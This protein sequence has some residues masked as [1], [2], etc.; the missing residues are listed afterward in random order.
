MYRIVKGLSQPDE[1]RIPPFNLTITDR[2]DA[3]VA[4]AVR[5]PITVVTRGSGSTHQVLH[6]DLPKGLEAHGAAV[7]PDG[8]LLLL[9][10]RKRDSDAGKHKALTGTDLYLYGFGD[11]ALSRVTQTPEWE[12]AMSFSTDGTAIYFIR[13]WKAT[14]VKWHFRWNI[15]R[16]D[17]AGQREEL[18]FSLPVQGI[19]PTSNL[20]VSP[21]NNKIMFSAIDRNG[22]GGLFLVELGAA[23]TLRKVVGGGSGRDYYPIYRAPSFSRSGKEVVFI[24]GEKRVDKPVW[25]GV[26]TEELWVMRTD[27]SAP[28]RVTSN[29]FRKHSPVFSP[30]GDRIYFFS[31]FR[32][33]R[34]V[35]EIW[36]V[37]GDGENCH[38]F[39]EL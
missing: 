10:L 36:M 17:V 37:D 12:Y 32:D 4:Y 16:M 8:Q 15:L 27:G 14:A 11:K 22:S 38:L 30:K 5:E 3:I 7:S 20:S 34:M 28:R 39:A 24:K 9:S 2:E 26:H 19:E 1:P 13:A 29:A 25:E 21:D 31:S 35:N 6:V 23:P 18:L 33:E